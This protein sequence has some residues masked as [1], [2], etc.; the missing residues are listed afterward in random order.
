M[1][2]YRYDAN[3]CNLT[4]PRTETAA[5]QRRSAAAQAAYDMNSFV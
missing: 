2:R 5:G 3:I 4:T 1:G